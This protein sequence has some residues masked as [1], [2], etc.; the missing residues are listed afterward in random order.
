MAAS[1]GWAV[2]WELRGLYAI[3]SMPIVYGGLSLSMVGVGG[4]AVSLETGRPTSLI[5]ILFLLGTP[6]GFHHTWMG[7]I[8]SGLDLLCERL[9]PGLGPL[10]ALQT[11]WVGLGDLL[12]MTIRPAVVLPSL[13]SFVIGCK[14]YY[15]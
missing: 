14:S 1:L 10:V 4:L 12:V 13:D 2:D 9:F 6:S 3:L 15:L 7:G 8:S 5:C 11:G